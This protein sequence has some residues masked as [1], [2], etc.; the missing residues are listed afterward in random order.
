[1]QRRFTYHPRG[2]GPFRVGPL[3][4]GEGVVAE[5]VAEAGGARSSRPQSDVCCKSSDAM[6]PF[7]EMIWPGLYVPSAQNALNATVL[8]G[9][10]AHVAGVQT[11]VRRRGLRRRRSNPSLTGSR[12]RCE[13]RAVSVKEQGQ[14]YKGAPMVES[15][16]TWS[17][18]EE[19]EAGAEVRAEAWMHRK[20]HPAGH[21][22][23][24]GMHDG[25]KTIAQVPGVTGR[26]CH[27]GVKRVNGIASGQ[28]GV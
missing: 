16:R 11:V 23:W 18:G 28:T 22:G 9:G 19:M 8:E 21:G 25:L 17:G 12:L 26:A 27:H 15:G 7:L 4:E 6:A 2:A 14:T 13:V 24:S 3:E 1:M 20:C 5:E 10:E